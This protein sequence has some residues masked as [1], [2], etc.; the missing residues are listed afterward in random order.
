[1]TEDM[2]AYKEIFLSES[3]EFLQAMTDGL[4]ELESD[5]GAAEPVET[6]F[7]GAHSLKGMA[8]AMGYGTTAEL[9]HKMETAMDAVR[10]KRRSADTGLIDLMLRATDMVQALIDAESADEPAPDI[11]LLVE[12]LL[13]AAEG[14]GSDQAE[15]PAAV[16]AQGAPG[17][18]VRVRVTL[19]ESCALKSVRAYMVIKRIS[20]IGTVIDTVPSTHDIEDERFDRAFEIEVETGATDEEL[21]DSA[22]HVSEVESAVVLGDED[23]RETE[24]DAPVGSDEPQTPVETA[25]DAP[26][27][28]R[29]PVT[30]LEETQSVRVSIGHLDSLVDLVGELVILR[31]RLERLSGEHQDRGLAEAVEELHR[32]TGELQHE[33]MQTRMVPVGNIFNRFPRMV[34]D[35]ALDLGKDVEF[36]TDGLDI[37]LDRTVLDEIGDPI[38]HLLRNSVDH[39][40]ESPGD[41]E[42]AGKPA[43]ATVRLAASR[44]RDQVCISVSD[45]GRGMNVDAI[46]ARA[47]ESGLAVA[48]DRES[49]SDR[50]ILLFTCAPGFST[51][52][53]ATKVSGRGVGMDVVKGKI[54]YLGGVLD[55]RTR[56]GEG[57]EFTL[58]LPLT[59]AIVQALLIGSAGQVFALALSGVSEVFSPE[60][61][62]V[63]TVDGTPVLVLRTDDVVPLYPLDALLSDHA[64]RDRLPDAGDQIVLVAHGASQNALLVD[65]IVGRHEIVIKPLSHIFRDARG[66]GGATL[67]GDGTV[68]LILDPRTLFPSKDG[69]R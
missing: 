65:R 34:R 58:T 67:L 52:A 45:D 25:P 12:D 4:L 32:V 49:Y 55:V 8:A 28:T 7:R 19:E 29:K 18:R 63:E 31:A 53:S 13:T 26:R 14:Q 17:R 9:T 66:I 10:Q 44:E 21:V 69:A 1:M 46:W 62:R 20:H 43:R 24:P 50:E 54:E 39:G 61:V 6:I 42:A 23:V 51:V 33:V 27:R 2:S 47:V 37:E 3:A 68:A 11:S 56:P 48:A 38:V 59:L 15:A 22:I 35:L 41:R 60:D 64:D 36:V 57:T 16:E 5:P 40:V 30:K